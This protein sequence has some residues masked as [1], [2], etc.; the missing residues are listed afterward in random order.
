MTHPCVADV[1]AELAAVALWLVYACRP[2][3]QQGRNI[4][5]VGRNQFGVPPRAWTRDAEVTN[6]E[7]FSKA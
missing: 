5:I 4:H 6:V 2:A 1:I 3:D 7:L